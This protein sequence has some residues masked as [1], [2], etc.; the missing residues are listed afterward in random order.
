MGTHL[1]QHYYHTLHDFC[2]QPNH[3]IYEQAWAELAEYL[4]RYAV[5]KM[6][7]KDEPDMLAQEALIILQKKLN[8]SPLDQPAT[9]IAYAQQ[10]LTSVAI[11][12]HRRQNSQKRGSGQVH[13]LERLAE[14]GGVDIAI[15]AHN[16]F[17]PTESD[18]FEQLTRQQVIAGIFAQLPTP[19]QQQVTKMI[20]IDGLKAV[21]IAGILNKKPAQIRQ[22]KARALKRLAKTAEWQ[23][24]LG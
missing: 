18:A 19:A 4:H 14:K 6:P 9:I 3:L 22:I 21:E 16:H 12:E 23:E 24:L 2:R 10:I 17:R 8:I 7:A 1:Y 20:F 11:S 15:N 13:S 5:S